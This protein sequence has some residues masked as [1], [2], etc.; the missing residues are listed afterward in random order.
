MDVW[1]WYTPGEGLRTLAHYAPRSDSINA[2]EIIASV[3]SAQTH[4][5]GGCAEGLESSNQKM[6]TMSVL[7][8]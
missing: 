1:F 5:F 3:Q 4:D 7:P 8:R 6:D 2:P